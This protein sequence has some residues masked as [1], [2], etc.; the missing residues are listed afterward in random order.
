MSGR[1]AKDASGSRHV[2]DLSGTQARHIS[3]LPSSSNRPGSHLSLRGRG[4]TDDK[5]VSGKQQ[6]P[7]VTPDHATSNCSLKE[8]WGWWRWVVVAVGAQ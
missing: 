6:G 3:C 8:R 2:T 7:T 5:K 1:E 4:G